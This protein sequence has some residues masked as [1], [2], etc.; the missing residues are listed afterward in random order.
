LAYRPPFVIEHGDTHFARMYGI[1]EA[2]RHD[3]A[4]SN[5]FCESVKHGY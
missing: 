4:G 5:E 1:G 3:H 2:D